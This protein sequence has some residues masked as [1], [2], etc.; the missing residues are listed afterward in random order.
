MKPMKLNKLSENDVLALDISTNDGCVILS[1]GTS[2][3]KDYIAR[4]EDFGI[5]EVFVEDPS[6]TESIS[7]KPGGKVNIVEARKSTLKNY[8]AIFCEAS[9]NN[10]INKEKL[11][12][13][14]NNIVYSVLSEIKENTID[15][16]YTENPYF[17]HYTHSLNTA[18]LA[19]FLGVKMNLSENQ[20]R[21]LATSALLHDVGMY[22]LPK[23]ILEKSGELTED[24]ISIVKRHTIHGYETSKSIKDI[25][26]SCRK[27]I[28]HHH[29]RYDG[30][31]YPFRLEGKGIPLYSRIIAVADIFCSL[32]TKT[33]NHPGYSFLDGYEFILAGSGLY[34]DPDVVEI[35]QKHFVMYPLKTKV[36]LNNGHRGFVL[37]QNPGFPDR[38]NIRITQ[39]DRGIDTFPITVNLIKKTSLKIDKVIND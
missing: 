9:K 14:I 2:L 27:A 1:K 15:I 36:L 23:E 26:E 16:L 22:K 35:F 7:I 38:P 10:G 19:V 24:D 25:S 12:E 30:R 11:D 28:L 34:F 3:S 21:E 6:A 17:C 18:S 33:R 20:L 37:S 29:E 39:D 5:N 32:T 8:C 31:G 4:L 13:S